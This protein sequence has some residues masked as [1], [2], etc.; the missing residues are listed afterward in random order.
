VAKTVTRVYWLVV[1]GE[2]YLVEAPNQA[3][4]RNLVSE[5][6]ITCVIPDQK[7]LHRLAAKGVPIQSVTG[8]A[9]SEVAAVVDPRQLAIPTQ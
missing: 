2:D 1:K 9:L 6:E 8:R 5:A 7:T 4:A 3:Q